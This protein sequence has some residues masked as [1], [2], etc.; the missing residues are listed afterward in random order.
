[1]KKKIHALQLDKKSDFMTVQ[2]S[3][4]ST[5]KI[6][7]D[8]KGRAINIGEVAKIKAIQALRARAKQVKKPITARQKLA[9]TQQL[10]K[11]KLP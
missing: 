10:R 2:T 4:K 7:I 3:R 11:T 9:V 8:K 5:H 1:M 6:V